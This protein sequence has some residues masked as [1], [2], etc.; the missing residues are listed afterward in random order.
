MKK[1]M[2]AAAMVAVAFG[3]EAAAL[4]SEYQEIEYLQSSG[5]QY[6]NTGVVPGA[7]F[8]VTARLN[9]GTYKHESVFFGTDWNTYR[10][11]F[12]QQNNNFCFHGN[13]TTICAVQSDTDCTVTI[14]PTT[15]SNGTFTFAPDGGTPFSKEVSLANNASTTSLRIFGTGAVNR[16][17]SFRLY[18]FKLYKREGT[19]GGE[20][21]VTT[22][23]P[24]LD[25]V[26]CEEK[27]TG[28]YGLYDLSRD[29][30]L[31]NVGTG[32]F[33]AGPH[34]FSSN[35]LEVRSRDAEAGTVDTSV[36][37]PYADGAVVMIK[38]TPA[39]G[40]RF[41]RWVGDIEKV[42]DELS[43]ETTV[44]MNG[45]ADLTALFGGEIIVAPTGGDYDN[46]NDAVAAANDYDTII[47]K[48]GTYIN[49]TAAFLVVTKP[50]AIVSENGKEHAFFRS[51]KSPS[52][53]KINVNPAY[54]GMQVNHE[55]AVVRG[56]TFFNFG[57]DQIQDP[58]GLGVYL[59]KG[60]VEDCVISNVVPNHGGAAIHLT[61]GLA[62]RL[63]LLNNKSG[64][65]GSASGAYLSGGTLRDCVIRNN[66][67][68]GD[69]AGVQLASSSARVLGCQI[70][71]NT[72]S[73]NGGGVYLQKGLVSDCVITNNS[74]TGGGVYQTGGT[75]RKCLV[76]GN[77]N[78]YGQKYGGVGSTGGTIEDCEIYE[79]TAYYPEG[80]QLYKTA[81]TVKGTTVAEGLHSVPCS[82]VVKIADGVTVENC[83]FQ[84]PGR[85][86]A[87]ELN[88]SDTFAE[89]EFHIHADKVVGLAP[90]TVN[91]AAAGTAA[92]PSWNF[93]DETMSSE[94][95]PSHKFEKA[96]RY[97]VILTAGGDATTLDILALPAKTYVGK[98][99]T[100]EFPY[101]TEEKATPDFQA[102]HD[103]VYAD[104]N[105]KGTVEVLADTYTYTGGDVSGSFKPW[106]LVNKNVTV[107][108]ATGNR[109]DVVFDAKQKIMTMFL[110]HPKAVLKDLTISNG[111]FNSSADYGGTL[112]MMAGFVTNC[113]MSKGYANFPG[114]VTV[115]GGTVIDSVISE[116]YM[117]AGGSDRRGGGLVIYGTCFVANSIIEKNNGSYGS[118]LYLEASG[119]IVSNCVIRSNT[120]GKNGGAGACVTSGLLTHCI[121]TNNTGS[122]GGGG[123][124]LKG[125]TVRNC[126][127]AD[128]SAKGTGAP[129]VG[130]H[131]G[132]GVSM[133]GSGTLE[134]CTVA[135][136]TSSSST[137]CD[138][139][140]QAGGTVRNCIFY[141][142]DDNPANDV[143]KTS[144]TATYSS[145]RTEIA[146]EGNQSEDPKLKAPGA[147]DFTLLFGSPCVDHGMTIAAVPTDILGTPRPVNDV[148]DIGA[149]E[150]DFSGKMGVTFDVDKTLGAGSV[151]VALTAESRA[152]SR[153]TPT[154]G[155]SAGRPT[156]RRSRRMCTP[157][158]TA[159]MMLRSRS[160][161]MWAMSPIR[162]SARVS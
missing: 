162:L 87:S 122:G 97:T 56:L 150:M 133:N 72:A 59:N 116:G 21:A 85:E 20:G 84:A 58:Q 34:V 131:G 67:A 148:Y 9:T 94:A 39:A 151:T 6:I 90:L 15:G 136:N 141:G 110:F 77:G 158:A 74:G 112:H 54:K 111:R 102:A 159:A 99:G 81:G 18:S 2:F 64:D 28:V 78:N 38:A 63:L 5:T 147:G 98:N 8:G 46:L 70:F 91:F 19:E 48:D 26:P 161:T 138:E 113:V 128:N 100:P 23:V 55:F 139:L 22:D 37:G 120:N 44:T 119:A 83:V 82:D 129:S 61:G 134:N 27:A 79:N 118:G 1:L 4:P 43:P 142:K 123:L 86:G 45:G 152:A 13:S 14:E 17:S 156:R 125:G 60:L 7:M 51:E 68:P 30:F 47:V 140:L 49:K 92:T 96:G 145:F 75:L 108:G 76:K 105:V 143:R 124:C 121:I 89:R 57:A 31:T 65:K 40:K 114:N 33:I 157:S 16:F 144:G 146:G 101:D 32:V 126:I 52:G 149:Y 132:G 11:C 127:I 160:L 29:K 93:G 153:P 73:G 115:R 69:G 103:A 80:K 41:F 24:Q 155:P 117:A 137:R 135:Y 53:G 35:T 10:Y 104:D 154:S 130:S 88:A 109:D 95:T 106:L 107:E 42:A 12:R 62:R 71:S 50:I 3:A 25:L 66:S 36:N